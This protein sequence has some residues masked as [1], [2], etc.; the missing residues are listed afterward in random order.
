MNIWEK[1]TNTSN[2]KSETIKEFNR[3]YQDTIL[4]IRNEETKKCK[5]LKYKYYNTDNNNHLFYTNSE[6]SVYILHEDVSFTSFNK[7]IFI[8][9]IEKGFYNS[10][11]N[12]IVYITKTPKRQWRRGVCEDNYKILN[13]SS[14]LNTGTN[15]KTVFYPD[16]FYILEQQYNNNNIKET[17]R[18]LNIFEICETFKHHRISKDFLLTQ[19]I[20]HPEGYSLFFH[21]Y[22]VGHFKKPN[23][24]EICTN[25]FFQEI[26]EEIS[27]WNFRVNLKFKEEPK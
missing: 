4:G 14:C 13:F 1:L 16:I 17:K 24:L 18:D 27:T 5:F 19:N 2:N 6:A 25:I 9:K 7:T 3:R 26:L 22:L 11:Q 21:K 23:E 15:Y 12:R 20:I 10:F 8:P